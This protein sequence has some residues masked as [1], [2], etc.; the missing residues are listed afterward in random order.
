MSKKFCGIYYIKNL[1]NEKI[2][3]GKSI[4]VISRLKG[5]YSIL[6]KG[7]HNNLYLQRAFNKY[8]ENLFEFGVIEICDRDCLSELEIFYIEKY[9]S[10]NEK[11]G[12]NLTFG[13][14]GTLG[15]IPSQEQRDKISKTNKGRKSPMEGKIHSEE[16]KKNMSIS[17]MGNTATRG[18]LRKT[19]GRYVGAV[20]L[21]NGAWIS[22]IRLEKRC[23]YLGCFD[24]EE[25]AALAYDKKAIEIYGMETPTNFPKNEVLSR[26]LV[27]KNKKLTSSYIGVSWSPESNKWRSVCYFNGKNKSLGFYADEKEAAQAYNIFVIENKIS[28][29][30]NEIFFDEG[31]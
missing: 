15:R 4:D 28:R 8:G 13:G 7:E 5:H 29:K 1:A 17:K 22:R 27:F 30:I 12:Y 11:N 20:L 14:D 9:N 31:E 2:Y 10:S 25:M 19:Y 26:K 23:L 16:S 6:K 24:T 21:S 3:I 18:M